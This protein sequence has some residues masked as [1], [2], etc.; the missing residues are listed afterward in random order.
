MCIRDRHTWIL[1]DDTVLWCW[2]AR[3]CGTASFNISLFLLMWHK[4]QPHDRY[5]K[6]MKWLALPWVWECAWRSV[7]PSLYLQRYVFW[8][9]FLNSI[10]VDRTF[11][12]VGELCWTSQFAVALLFVDREVNNQ[13][14]TLWI[15]IS[16]VLA[17]IIYVAAECVSY[18]NVA[19][20][21]ELWCAV[22][23]LLDGLSFLLMAPGAICLLFKCP[24]SLYSSS[25][26]AF[27]GITSLL[28]LVY[29]YYNISVD[30]PMYMERY[31]QDQAHHKHYMLSLI[32]I[33]E[34][35]RLLSISYAVFCLKKKT[36]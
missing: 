34:P 1:D 28:C 2:Y 6:A 18:Y 11:A 9:T 26:K 13:K 3:M 33:S 19:T 16:G 15:Q 7:F 8:D 21:N 22:E 35:T 27:L 24:G 31:R 4:I 14:P 12:C 23:V 25:A 17:I 30:A 29:P 5:G 36:K 32:H 10:I 20:T